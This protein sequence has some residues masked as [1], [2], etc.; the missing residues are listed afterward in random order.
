MEKILNIIG[1]AI[2]MVMTLS[3]MWILMMAAVAV[4]IVML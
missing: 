4:A 1:Y 3:V 2:G